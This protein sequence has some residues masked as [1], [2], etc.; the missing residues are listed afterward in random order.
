MRAKPRRSRAGRVTVTV[1][2]TSE[3]AGWFGLPSLILR[4]W[5]G[6]PR[7]TPGVY[8]EAVIWLAME[9]I[10]K[11]GWIATVERMQDDRV[12]GGIVLDFVCDHGWDG[13]T[14]KRWYR[15]C[16]GK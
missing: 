3:A 11:P 8:G 1:H 14:S 5:R 6:L 4:V 15:D 13:D 9:P 16:G 12:E 7:W 2:R 10:D